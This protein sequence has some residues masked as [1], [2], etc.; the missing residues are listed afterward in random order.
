MTASTAFLPWPKVLVTRSA[1]RSSLMRVTP[2]AGTRV[3]LS[4][5]VA[6]P[7]WSSCGSTPPARR[8]RSTW[9]AS[10]RLCDVTA[11]SGTDSPGC[12]VGPEAG[13]VGSSSPTCGGSSVVHSSIAK[14][15][16]GWNRQ[17]DGG[18][19]R[20][21]GEPGM[22]R[23]ASAVAGLRHQHGV[24]QGRRVRVAR[25]SVISAASPISTILPAYMTAIRL[26]TVRS[27]G[28]RG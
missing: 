27:T 14:P 15:Q 19:A 1:C 18:S 2:P 3:P 21:G 12:F 9:S 16:R 7:S 20:L 26:D 28:G 22:P 5:P 17:P 4:P 23:P 8:R 25:A 24:E 11:S 13:G 10:A 6:S